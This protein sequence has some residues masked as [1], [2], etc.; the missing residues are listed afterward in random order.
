MPPEHVLQGGER[1]LDLGEIDTGD[2]TIR[3]DLLG[4]RDDRLGVPLVHAPL[5]Q[6]EQ[7]LNVA[8]AV[9]RAERVAPAVRR[10]ERVTAGLIA[11]F[12]HGQRLTDHLVPGVSE[13][14]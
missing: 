9:R 6:L 7:L 2:E 1:R 14:G 3:R 12:E 11:P 5:D 8:A 4:R 10:A 13:R